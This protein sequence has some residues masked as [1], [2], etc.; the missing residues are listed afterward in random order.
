LNAAAAATLLTLCDYETPLWLDAPFA[1]GEAAAWLRFHTGAPTVV[2]PARAAFALLQAETLD[3]SRFARGAP[4]YPDRSTTLVVQV[5]ALARDGELSLA[6]PGVEGERR[7]AFGP[8]AQ[9][10]LAQ[11]RENGAAFP[12]GVDLILACGNRLAALPRTTRIREVG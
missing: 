11:W 10:F 6:G 8:R 7:F 3:L 2:A 1:D 5:A 12:L 9:G 4:E